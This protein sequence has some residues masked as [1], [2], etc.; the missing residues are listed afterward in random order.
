MAGAFAATD[1]T[2]PFFNS[3][4]IPMYLAHKHYREKNYAGAIDR[5]MDIKA[6]DWR[7]ACVEW[8]Q[9]RKVR[10]EQNQKRFTEVAEKQEA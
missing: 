7:L 4:A 10:Y 8:L 3:V 6:D 1:Y 5:A 2:E 9:R